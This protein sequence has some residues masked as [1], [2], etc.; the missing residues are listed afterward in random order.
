MQWTCPG[1]CSAG[2]VDPEWAAR[3]EQG[4]ILVV[5]VRNAND[6]GIYT[7]NVEDENNMPD[8]I[9]NYTLTVASEFGVSIKAEYIF[10]Q[11]TDR[12][13]EILSTHQTEGHW[14]W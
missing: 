10:T 14:R 3:I 4:N 6:N 7:C 2:P 11:Q 12:L 13:M 9:T 5:N 1:N 8:V